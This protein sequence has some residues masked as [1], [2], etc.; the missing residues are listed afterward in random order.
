MIEGILGEKIGMSRWFDKQGNSVPVTIIS[1]GPCFVAENL[2][3]RIKIG[4]K[5][6]KESRLNKPRMG[7]LQKKNLPPLKYLKEVRWTGKEDE[8]PKQGEKLNADIFEIGDK[9]D[10][11]GTSKG[12]GFAGLIK[13]WGFRGGPGSHGSTS[14]R[15]A[16]SI[17]GSSYPS[18]VWP[19]LRMPGRKGADK[20]KALNLEIVEIDKTQNIVAVKGSVPGP[21]KSLVFIRRSARKKK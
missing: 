4:Y 9:V 18:R 5:E 10:V 2:E 3:G 21:A 12:K 14:H 11:Q 17:G 6:T 8:Q 7:Y 16:G 19:G 15:R 20:V 13:R 1:C